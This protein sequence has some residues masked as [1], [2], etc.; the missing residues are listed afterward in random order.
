MFDP[1]K[2]A[3]V[4]VR[5]FYVHHVLT[6]YSRIPYANIKRYLYEY[7]MLSFK[8]IPSTTLFEQIAEVFFEAVDNPEDDSLSAQ[9]EF[10]IYRLTNVLDKA[11]GRSSHNRQNEIFFKVMGKT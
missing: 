3:K 6:K 5:N 8:V 10:A 4:M 1:E 7:F 2:H 11:E 9:E